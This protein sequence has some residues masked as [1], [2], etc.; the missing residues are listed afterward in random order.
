MLAVTTVKRASVLNV[1]F[2]RFCVESYLCVYYKIGD[3]ERLR[4]IALYETARQ[5]CENDR[6]SNKSVEFALVRKFFSFSR[7]W[8]RQAGADRSID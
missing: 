2:L 5:I 4:Q 8:H 6:V 3:I 1:S 7:L